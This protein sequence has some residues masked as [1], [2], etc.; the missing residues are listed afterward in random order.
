MASTSVAPA[1]LAPAGARQAVAETRASSVAI[2]ATGCTSGSKWSGAGSGL[3][4][5]DPPNAPLAGA[6]ASDFEGASGRWGGA[7]SA[8][9]SAVATG[10]ASTGRG[11]LDRATAAA[12]WLVL[13]RAAAALHGC[14]R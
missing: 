13:A 10:A 7:A 2:S 1:S 3:A 5:G 9:G 11:G 12:T 4:G 6:P 14:L 8:P